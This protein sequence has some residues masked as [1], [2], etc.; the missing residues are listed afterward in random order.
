MDRCA[1]QGVQGYSIQ[2]GQRFERIAPNAY[3]SAAV[4]WTGSASDR[5]WRIVLNAYN[6]AIGCVC[7]YLGTTNV[8]LCAPS[9]IVTN[10]CV[11][12]WKHDAG[13]KP[14]KSGL[15]MLSGNKPLNM[16]SQ[17][18][19]VKSGVSGSTVRSIMDRRQ[20]V[21]D[22]KSGSSIFCQFFDFIFSSVG[23]TS[24]DVRSGETSTRRW[25]IEC[26]GNNENVEWAREMSRKSWK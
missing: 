19:Y 6:G 21:G 10:S 4:Q 16:S 9:L 24:V 13:V 7:A 22:W 20:N 23:G 3:N 15:W 2:R 11:K 8:G 5:F 1:L 14:R 12:P 18:G 26:V 17:V 25:R